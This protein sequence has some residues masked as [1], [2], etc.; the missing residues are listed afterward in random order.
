MPRRRLPSLVLC[1]W[2][3][4][5]H[6]GTDA[7]AVGP[8]RRLSPHRS[9]AGMVEWAPGALAGGD[10]QVKRCLSVP[11]DMECF[12]QA[13]LA[14]ARRPIGLSGGHARLEPLVV[15]EQQRGGERLADMLH[16]G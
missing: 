14:F 2:R 15:P 13:S 7:G 11:N 16:K 6:P 1:P 4:A 3:R 12:T 10:T 9:V 5:E 8:R